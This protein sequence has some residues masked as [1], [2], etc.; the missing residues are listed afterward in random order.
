MIRPCDLVDP[1][2][3]RA[4]KSRLSGPHRP[5]GLL[6]DGLGYL[7]QMPCPVGVQRTTSLV[8]TVKPGIK[9]QREDRR[10]LPGGPG[11]R[12][13]FRVRETERRD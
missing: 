12:C 7:S 9:D 10:M 2:R 11:K 8:A 1:H 13:V 6:M 4:G 5:S 3:K